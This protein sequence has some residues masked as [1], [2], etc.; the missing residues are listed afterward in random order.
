MDA[1]PCLDKGRYSVFQWKRIIQGI[2]P[3][4]EEPLE[5]DTSNIR[6]DAPGQ[7]DFIHNLRI[8]DALYTDAITGTTFLA[9]FADDDYYGRKSLRTY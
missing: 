7:K 5:I 6:S 3:S 1:I 2:K 4:E 9:D 8:M